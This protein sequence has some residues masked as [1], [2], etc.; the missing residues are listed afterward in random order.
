VRWQRSRALRALHRT[1]AIPVLDFTAPAEPF[2]AK[3]ATAISAITGRTIE[4]QTIAPA[5]RGEQIHHGSDTPGADPALVAECLELHVALTGHSAAPG[6]FPGSLVEQAIA[7]DAAAARAA[8]AA[9]R[10][11]A[12]ILTPIASAWLRAKRAS[13]VLALLDQIAL[14]PQAAA[15]WRAKAL[16]DLGQAAAAAATLATHADD[17]YECG[18]LRATA[19]RRCG[20]PSAIET[21][22]ALLP[23]TV[24]P[25]TI[26][27]TLAA[28]AIDD[29]E[30]DAALDHL[31]RAIADAPPDRCGR[32]R[33][34]R[35]ELL[36]ARGDLVAA[37]TELMTAI[38]QDPSW[39]RAPRMLAELDRNR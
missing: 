36:I 6:D 37:R 32:W 18:L 13:E 15:L 33:T 10:D 12:A 38:D 39:D 16:L 24:Q 34:R 21:L 29:G 2:L 8:L 5:Y 17:W 22:R 23:R 35:A 30:P 19:L 25:S 31:A 26:H 14:D 27:G 28:W 9:A 4:A 20:D 7:G 11:P 3:A 1:Q